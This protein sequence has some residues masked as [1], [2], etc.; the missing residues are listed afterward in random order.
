MTGTAWARPNIALVKYWGK[1][2]DVLNLPFTDS[3]SVTL[4][5][6]ATVARVRFERGLAADVVTVDGVLAESNVH[7]RV[8]QF[9]DRVRTLA[10]TRLRVRVDSTTEAPIGAGLASSAAAF[11]ALALATV[12]ALHLS[13]DLPGL[14][15]LARQGSGS[16]CRSIFPGFVQW[17]AGERADGL[18]SVAYPLFP[19]DHWPLTLL[20]VVVDGQAKT[21]SSR[22]AMRRT[23]M[24]SPFYPAF[25]E[26]AAQ[27]LSTVRAALAARDWERLGPAVE[28][29]ALAMHA[30]SLAARPPICFWRPAT[31]RVLEAVRRLRSE[32]FTAYCTLDA[33]PNPVVLCPNDEATAVARRLERLAGPTGIIPC[34][35]GPGAG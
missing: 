31:V 8:A 25:R 13:L 1:R 11:A 15:R 10:G 2:D 7:E 20:A 12:R 23:V 3:L 24:T 5:R 29:H 9:L 16:A 22:E 30:V 28:A 4:D 19:P 34:R 26:T 18:D 14:S 27:D 35:P 33:G 6:L 17:N 21:L 32:G